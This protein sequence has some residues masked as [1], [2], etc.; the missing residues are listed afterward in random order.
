MNPIFIVD[1]YNLIYQVGQLKKSLSD[2][3]EAARFNLELAI[4][5]YLVAKNVS[6]YLIYDGAKVGYFESMTYKNLKVI[7]SKPTENADQ[8]IKRIVRQHPRKNQITVV[9]LDN[10]ILQYIRSAGAGSMTPREFFQR[11]SKCEQQVDIS[12]KYNAT[13]SPE[14]IQEWLALFENHNPNNDD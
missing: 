7:F 14:E 6:V 1:G 9:T 11:I 13:L 5:N 2:S 4:R 12:Q 3:L 8:L 10:D